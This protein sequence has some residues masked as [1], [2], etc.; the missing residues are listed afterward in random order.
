MW[1]DSVPKHFQREGTLGNSHHF[2]WQWCRSQLLRLLGLKRD[3][4]QAA[5]KACASEVESWELAGMGPEERAAALA[6]A[7]Q[8]VQELTSHPSLQGS[9]LYAAIR[10]IAFVPA[11]LVCPVAVPSSEQTAL[12]LIEVPIPSLSAVHSSLCRPTCLCAIIFW[13]QPESLASSFLRLR[14]PE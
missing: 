6:A 2:T 8:L 9:S 5:F 14:A 1:I 3:L 12:H 4:N 11:S 10:D 7:R 13:Q